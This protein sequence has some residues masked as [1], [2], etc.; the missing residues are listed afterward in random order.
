[1]RIE[2]GAPPRAKIEWLVY[3]VLCLGVAGYFVYD[4]KVGYP[5]ANREEARKQLA[6]KPEEP[7]ELRDK[8]TK[9]EYDALLAEFAAKRTLGA[10]RVRS[11]G[12]PIRR[13]TDP[14]NGEVAETF[15]D[16]LGYGVIVSRG[17]A[18]TDVR[19]WRDWKHS[20][21]TIEGQMYFAVLCL[22]LMLYPLS[23]L[24][25]ALTL[26]VVLDDAGLD[27]AGKR[28]GFDAM[29][30]WKN[31]DRKGWVDLVYR[32]ESGEAL[33]RLDN[34]RVKGWDALLAAISE[35]RGFKNPAREEP[36]P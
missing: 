23:R 6:L 14:Q 17:G 1:M 29:T 3:T 31:F 4:W 18:V 20:A 10:D 12:E 33:L 7:L 19:P 8:P 32:G 5:S 36:A 13:A 2:S 24:I 22:L 34:Q 25:R 26:R 30:G 35:K 28:V 27:Y 15:G 21:S 16:T 9:G 11:L